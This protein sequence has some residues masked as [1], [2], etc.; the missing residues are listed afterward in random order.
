[1]R[2]LVKSSVSDTFTS[3]TF[4]PNGLFV[5]I[6]EN[7]DVYFLHAVYSDQKNTWAWHSLFDHKYIADGDFVT[8]KAAINS[9][10]KQDYWKEVIEFSTYSEM[11]SYLYARH[12]PVP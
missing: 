9:A 3:D 2:T 10:V 1:M 7:D 6:T 11:I 4:D 8:I 12:H 5:A